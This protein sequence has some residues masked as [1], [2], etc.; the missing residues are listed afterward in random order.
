MISIKTEL[1][2]WLS[3]K[4]SACQCRRPGFDTWSGE[5]P[6]AAQQPSLCATVTEP[7]LWSP[8]AT[9]TEPTR[10]KYRSPGACAPQREKPLQREA[11]TSQLEKSPRSSQWEKSPCSSQREK[12]PRSNK[13]PPQP[14]QNKYFLKAENGRVLVIS[15]ADSF[16]AEWFVFKVSHRNSACND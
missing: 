8:G 4:E 11:C 7:V 16:T 9:T 10:C 5:I 13:D 1:P 6:H 14:K 12:S 2:W 3:G 15:F